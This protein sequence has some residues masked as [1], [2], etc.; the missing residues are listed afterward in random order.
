MGDLIWEHLRNDRPTVLP[1]I[2]SVFV[3][4]YKRILS[5][6]SNSFQSSFTA[7]SLK[8]VLELSSDRFMKH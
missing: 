7:L 1:Y 5:L 3:H 6:M 8:E 2:L 4:V